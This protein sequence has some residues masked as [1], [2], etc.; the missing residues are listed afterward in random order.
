MKKRKNRKVKKA[1]LNSKMTSREA[2]HFDKPACAGNVEKVMNMLYVH[3]PFIVN[4]IRVCNI[5][6]NLD[7]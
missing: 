4:L 3:G 5:I 1:V 7:N 2:T 6:M